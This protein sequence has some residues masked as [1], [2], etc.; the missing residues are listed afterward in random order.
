M[1]IAVRAA[2]LVPASFPSAVGSIHRCGLQ[3]E[4]REPGGK[5]GV[6]GATV[7]HRLTATTGSSRQSFDSPIP[8]DDV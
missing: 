3:E 7:H 8:G 6:N 2:E 4:D 1:A 5:E